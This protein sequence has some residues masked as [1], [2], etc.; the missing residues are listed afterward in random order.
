[1]RKYLL[2]SI[3]IIL[4]FLLTSTCAFADT[5]SS[6]LLVSAR[7]VPV[8][9]YNVLH[10]E[11]TI[12]V[13][14]EDINRGYIDVENAVIYRIKTNSRNGHLLVYSRDTSLFKEIFILGNHYVQTMSGSWGEIPMPYQGNHYFTKELGFR[15]QVTENMKPGTYPW[16]LA[17]TL[18]SL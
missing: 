15:F 18:S 1:M 7:V 6:N 10:Q 3:S 4:T 9:Q 11:N 17:I 5:V 8:V 13:T 12:T 14:A 2:I 16:P